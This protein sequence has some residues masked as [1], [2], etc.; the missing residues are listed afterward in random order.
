MFI[1][2]M[3]FHVAVEGITGDVTPQSVVATIKAMP[4]K[5]LPGGGGLHFRCNGS[6]VAGSP[7]LCVRGGLV[8]QLDA[9][10]EPTTYKPVG[11][12]PF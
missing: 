3:A 6:A 9:K 1:S 2:V 7:A 12:S 4:S 5:L 8:T 10:G 11:D